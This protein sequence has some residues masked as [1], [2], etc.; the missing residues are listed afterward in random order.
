MPTYTKSI[1]IYA[2]LVFGVE[3]KLKAFSL[4]AYQGCHI[5]LGSEFKQDYF[6]KE[7]LACGNGFFL[8]L[9]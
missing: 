7:G 6:I 3:I 9:Y 8:R 5:F 2:F 4:K 1:H